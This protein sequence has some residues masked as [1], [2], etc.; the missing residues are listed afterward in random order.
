MI[1]NEIQFNLDGIHSICWS[2]TI[3]RFII[4]TFKEILIL[5]DKIMMLEQCP[6]SLSSIDWWRGTCSDDTLF[7]SSVEWGSSI[8][9]LDL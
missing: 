5:E 1:V 6:I 3:N 7:L 4:I 2:S 8:H 9:E